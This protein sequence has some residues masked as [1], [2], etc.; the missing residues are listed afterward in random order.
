MKEK[1]LVWLPTIGAIGCLAIFAETLLPYFAA[2]RSGAETDYWP[3]VFGL[4]AASALVATITYF[5]APPGQYR[6]HRTIG[7]ALTVAVSFALLFL[8]VVL[9]T[10]GS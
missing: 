8:F 1:I 6:L 4:L 2:H 3:F 5:L 9:N 10:S 7:S